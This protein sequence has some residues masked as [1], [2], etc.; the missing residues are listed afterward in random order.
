MAIDRGRGR[1]RIG[2]RT[3]TRTS[4][5]SSSS[6][7]PVVEHIVPNSV[8]KEDP[9]G[10]CVVVELPEFKKEEVKLQI[11]GSSER[12]IVKGERQANEEKRVRFEVTF[13][14]PTDS[15]MDNINGNFASEI[16]YVYVPKRNRAIETEKVSNSIVESAEEIENEEH[17]KDREKEEIENENAELTRKWEQECDMSKTAVE[18]LRRNKGIVITAVVAFSFGFAILGLSMGGTEEKDKHE[19]EAEIEDKKEKEEKAEDAEG[20]EEE[21]SK[22]KKKK[23]KKDKEG[24]EEKKKKKNPEDKMDPE[25]LKTKLEKLDTKMQALVAKKE[26][27]LKLLKEAEQAAANANQSEASEPPEASS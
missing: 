2:T 15:D 19:D 20:E 1:I 8:W 12:I 7:T 4:S 27:I 17:E 5:S 16:L 3:R 9:S 23:K 25:N 11:D 10:H 6:S 22:E 24:K 14:V 26:E 18:I 13:A 21:E